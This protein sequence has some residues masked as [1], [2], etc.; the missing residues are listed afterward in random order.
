MADLFD[1]V[2]VA[3]RGE[4]AVRIIRTLRRLGIRSVA[5]FSDGDAAAAHVRLA[6]SAVRIG[7]TP[8]AQSYLDIDTVVAAA[9][10]TGAQ[11]VHPG[12]GFLAENAAF[13]AACAAAG[14]VFVGPP[15]GAIEAMGDKIRAK[16]LVAAA[17]VPVVP[18][19]SLVGTPA[20]QA[21][22]AR[23]LDFP[24]LVK[25]AAGGGGKGLRVVTEPDDLPAQLAAATREAVAA[26]GDGTLLVERYLQRPRH[27]EV[28]VLADTH[29][30]AVHLG[31]RECSLQR[32]HQKVV[33]EAPAPFF[34]GGAHAGMREAM[35]EAA[36]A[37][38]RACGYVGA[39]TVELIVPED[40]GSFFFLE[41][42]TRLQVEHPVTE[43]VT[44]L[45]L[46][47][48]QLRVA[49]GQPLPITQA[50]VRLDGHAVE[51]RINAEDPA[52]GYLPSGGRILLLDE[53]EQEHVRVDSGI[54][55][56]DVVGG[57]YDPLLAKVIAWAPDRAAALRRL[58]RALAA[59][60]ILGLRTNV[61]AL[62]ALLIDPDVVAGRLDTGLV[63]RT[64]PPVAT[65]PAH[66]LVAAAMDELDRLEQ[67]H[68]HDPDP[69]SAPGAWRVGGPAW[70]TWRFSVGG[71]EHVVRT[72]GRAGD[73]L[74]QVD[75]A[76]PVAAVGSSGGPDRLTVV[77]GGTER[78]LSRARSDTALWLGHDGTAYEVRPTSRYRTGHA[79]VAAADTTVRSPMPGT[80]LL[81]HARDGDE[82]TQ[83]QPLLV[84]EAMKMEHVVVAPAAGTVSGLRVRPGDLVALE[85]P[86]AH[87]EPALVSQVTL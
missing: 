84:V 6:D 67:A 9:V 86:L 49:A 4:I 74:V 51:A 10:A 60:S 33:E 39:G 66:V 29:G 53:P 62:R 31:E 35:L 7:P 25:P 64:G 38:T 50:D 79:R 80:V 47:E 72:R 37:A 77:L 19:R 87:V 3:N 61:P 54:R 13:A 30:A 8:A 27:L 56:G 2:L 55:A 85:Q 57:S 36:L 69:W 22:Q 24:L 1:G 45:D 43:L 42:N 44:G 75:D 58:D 82:V 18:G 26:F 81:V 12:Y 20:E 59:T 73:A 46:V 68:A 40:A 63:E 70:V 78:T 41:M 48:L 23:E 5:V 14:L 52:R 21:E 83:G 17:G 28:Q 32:R 71:D 34:A 76:D 65:V 11:A 16:A 15:P